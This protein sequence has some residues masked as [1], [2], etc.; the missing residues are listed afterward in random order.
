MKK[1]FSILSLILPLFLTACGSD[2]FEGRYTDQEGLK[3][4]EFLPDGELRIVNQED[5]TF[6]SYEYNANDKKL[7]L[8]SDE[9][10]PSGTVT[11]NDDGSLQLNATT[12]TRS[13]DTAMLANSTWIG[14]EGQY[15]FTLTFTPTEKGLETYSEL[16]T[17]YDD[18]MSYIYQTD[19]SITVL[20]GNK[21]LLDKTVYT[22]SDVSD[23]S[24]KLSIGNQSM[25]MHKHPKDTRI[26]FRDGYNNI[27]E[28]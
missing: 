7:T 11:V 12:L 10:T 4:Y 21:L 15:T 14:N 25:V 13:V 22:V 23:T 6:A 27:D 20:S 2:D 28:E 9:N 18:D 16:V 26:E 3:S 5:E 24:L 1:A 8:M 19:D 17:Y